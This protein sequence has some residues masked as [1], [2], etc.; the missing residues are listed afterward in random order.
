MVVRPRRR[1]V[2]LANRVDQQF[3]DQS[4]L[5]EQVQGI[6][7]RRL[8]DAAASPFQAFDDLVGRQ[9]LRFLQN[10]FSDFNALRRRLNAVCLKDLEN[11]CS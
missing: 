1:I 10:D 11:F 4:T 5:A 6:V 8:G 7:N 9:M 2:E 3:L